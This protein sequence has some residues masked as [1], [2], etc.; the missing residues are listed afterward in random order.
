MDQTPNQP[1]LQG[2]ELLIGEILR[3][4]FESVPESPAASMGEDV[5]TYADLARDSCRIAHALRASGAVRFGDRVV[6]WV[7]TSLDVLSLFFA[8]AKLG[9]VF[10]PLNARLLA[11]EAGSVAL[12]AKGSL[13]ITD[14]GRWADAA[15]VAELAGIDRVALLPAGENVETREA[16]LVLDPTSLDDPREPVDEPRLCESDPHVIFFTSG[17]T[18]RPKGVVLSH[19]ANWL[20]G[21]QGV[22]RDEPERTVCMFPLF[23]MAGFTLAVSAWQTRGEIILAEPNA[24]SILDAIASRRANRLYALPLVWK[25]ILEEDTTRWDLSSLTQLDTG[26]SATPIELLEE[27]KARFPNPALRIYYGSTECGS[28]TALCN[29]DVMRKPG[30]VGRAAAS[31]DIRIADDGEILVRSPYLMDGYFGDPDASRLAFVDGWFATG[32]LGSMDDEGFLSV[33][34]RKKE[35]LRTGG[36]SVSPAEVEAVLRSVS[37]VAEVAVIGLPD[38]DWGEVVC[39]AIVPAE[40]AE[41]TLAILRKHCEGKLAGFKQPRRIALLESLPRTAATAQVQRTLLVEQILA[42]GL[43]AES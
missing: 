39:A 1:G 10:A 22:F 21:F 43:A 23:H 11:E 16:D 20:R 12:L 30:S 24:K 28:A 40:G 19:R 14:A 25:R 7:D 34:G 13:L 31:V 4:A 18:G 17:S 35:V 33:V 27:M 42:K 5:R 32:D 36:E 3:R 15:R 38:V 41:L 2:R 9:A 26:T 37:G 29:A 6:C 8:I